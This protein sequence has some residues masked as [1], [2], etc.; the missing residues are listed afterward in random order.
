[1]EARG[2][3]RHERAKSREAKL[4]T[5]ESAAADAAIEA[6]RQRD[7]ATTELVGANATLVTLRSELA[8]ATRLFRESVEVK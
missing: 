2:A 7:E 1:M 4:V 5:R 6:Q 8:E 3:R